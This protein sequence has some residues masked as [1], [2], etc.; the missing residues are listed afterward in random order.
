MSTD[1]P[2]IADFQFFKS[3][4]SKKQKEAKVSIRTFADSLTKLAKLLKQK[5]NPSDDIERSP[6]L[7]RKMLAR[8]IIE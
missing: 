8:D 1:N 7:S 2:F 4:F 3:R 6:G 5:P